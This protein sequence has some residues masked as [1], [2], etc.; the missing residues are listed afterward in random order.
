MKTYIGI[1]VSKATL[2]IAWRE[3]TNKHFK[4]SNDLN[5]FKEIIRKCPT[6][7]HFVMEATGV[8]YLHL[9]YFLIKH[10][11]DI[12]VVNPLSIKRF[13]QMTLSRS[14]TDKADSFLIADYAS[15]LTPKTWNAPKPKILEMQQLWT[16]S[17][18][19]ITQKQMLKNQI[20]AFARNPFASKLALL[21]IKSILKILDKEML[22][23]E[24]ELDK[25]VSTFY[26][27]EIEIVESIPGIGSK[28]SQALIIVS[29]GFTEFENGRNLCSFIGLTPRVS[30]SG[31]S[32]NSKG[33]ITKMGQ[34]KI[35]SLLYMCALTAVRKNAGCK[36]L[37]ERFVKLGKPK[38]VALV[39][40]AAKLVRQ[41]VTMIKQDK[42]FEEKLSLS[43]CF[44]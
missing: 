8:Y 24:K 11:F 28:T 20:E 14:K 31:T 41:A 27:R 23:I 21:S 15:S 7:S 43:P 3:K 2:D 44:Q 37:Y 12:S 29:K 38:K 34:G 6:N 25:I 32:L 13:S 30:Q 18:K 42:L 1:D 26:P 22:R 40:V 9:A 17:D 4:V 5:G 33:K 36:Q 10:N 16:L 35:R 39:A 19:I